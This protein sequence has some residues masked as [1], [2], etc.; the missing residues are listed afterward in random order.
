M[1][2]L[3]N[4]FK[5]PALL[6]GSDKS[7]PIL[8][9]LSGGA[10][11][12]ALLHLLCEYSKNSGCRLYAAHLNHGI[13]GEEYSGEADRDEEFC[14]DICER[15]GVEL[16][17]RRLDIPKQAKS[18]G[19]SLETEARDARYAF[20][21]EIMQQ[22]NIKILATAHNADDDLET[23][24]YN[25]ARGCGIEG[26]S[27]IPEARKFDLADGSI[28]IRPI[29]RA[30]KREILDFC[31]DN[32]IPFVNDSTNFEDDCT[33]NL[34]RHKIIPALSDIFPSVR[35]SAQRLA[36]FAREDS[37]FILGEAR[38]FIEKNSGQ[39]PI[40]LLK[41]L[42]PSL[43]K[44]VVMLA[45]ADKTGKGLES[46]HISSVLSLL[47]NEK[48]GAS[49]SL[50]YKIC[51]KAVDG[52]LCF[53]EDT[54]EKNSLKCYSQTL[55]FGFNEITGTQFALILSLDEPQNTPEGYSLYSSAEIKALDG[56]NVRNRTEGVSILDGG[57]NKKIKKLM[58]DKK[59]PLY[60]RDTLPLVFCENEIIYAPKCAIA[61]KA[62][63]KNG[64]SIIYIGIY[65][66]NGGRL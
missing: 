43:S 46:V 12:S 5:A 23:Q 48:N 3:P 6:S 8:L 47:D 64:D 13:R 18:S 9:A 16:F 66:S 56:Y 57:V 29:L 33:R 21:A 60:D 58:C 24:I 51:A 26:M 52:F 30:E 11:S 54:K 1:S 7:S 22:K 59:I 37:E 45:Y 62:K 4:F 41:E 53:E 36:C 15:L 38:A 39:L 35:R 19:K 34:I 49:I 40:H 20:F 27:G 28:I 61:D 17:V 25:L 10:D 50:P 31:R 55:K 42:H 65:K 44:R 32:S 2:I 63:P 14:R